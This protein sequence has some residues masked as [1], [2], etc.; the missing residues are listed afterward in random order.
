MLSVMCTV[1]DHSFSTYARFS[2][3]LTGVRNVSIPEN[4]AYVPSK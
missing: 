2:E 4:F 1:R 3:K